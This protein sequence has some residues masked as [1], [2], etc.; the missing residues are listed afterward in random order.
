[1]TIVNIDT[2]E[3]FEKDLATLKIERDEICKISKKFETTKYKTYCLLSI[4]VSGHI[5]VDHI[6]FGAFCFFIPKGI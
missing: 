6:G 4:L 3:Q 1:M 2:R 5:V